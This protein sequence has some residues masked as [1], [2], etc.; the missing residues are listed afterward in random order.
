[1]TPLSQLSDS[2]RFGFDFTELPA[3]APHSTA[4]VTALSLLSVHQFV[5]N[6]VDQCFNY[7]RKIVSSAL[8][9]PVL[10]RLEY[11]RILSRSI[12]PNLDSL[13]TSTSA[14]GILGINHCHAETL[15]PS[16]SSKPNSIPNYL[17]RD[18]CLIRHPHIVTPSALPRRLPAPLRF[19]LSFVSRRGEMQREPTW[20]STILIGGLLCYSCYYYIK[21]TFAIS[22]ITRLFSCGLTSPPSKTKLKISVDTILGISESITK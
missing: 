7:G 10:I 8:E 1:M 20:F 3:S 6:H 18:V 12:H 2:I 13:L 4:T 21:W 11:A 22:R 5:R 16:R 17:V 14:K 19:D 9:L 15:D